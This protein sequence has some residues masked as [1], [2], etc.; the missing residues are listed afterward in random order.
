MKVLVSKED[1]WKLDSS[2]FCLE[3]NWETGYFFDK[4]IFFMTGVTTYCEEGA[5][6]SLDESFLGDLKSSEFRIYLMAAKRH[7]DIGDAKTALQYQKMVIASIN[8]QRE[9]KDAFFI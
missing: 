7:F 9:I 6:V 3:G 1:S 2:M 5:V 8:L 4:D